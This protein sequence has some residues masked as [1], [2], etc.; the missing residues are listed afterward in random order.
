AIF[1]ALVEAAVVILLG[2]WARSKATDKKSN[3]CK[4]TFSRPEYVH[5]PV[6]GY[7]SEGERGEASGEAPGYGYRLVRY[8]D[9]KLPAGER[10]DPLKPGGFPVLFVP[11]HLGSYEQVRTEQ[12]GQ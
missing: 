9:R 12:Y 7:P 6:A 11:G 4:M 10:V 5:L 1:R 3:S 2:W 8:M